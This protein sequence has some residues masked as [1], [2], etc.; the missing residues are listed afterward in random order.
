MPPDAPPRVPGVSA[1]PPDWRFEDR[2]AHGSDDCWACGGPA[3]YTDPDIQGLVLCTD[4]GIIYA[5]AWR[6]AQKAGYPSDDF[7]EYLTLW[8]RY[9]W[10]CRFHQQRGDNE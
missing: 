3:G 8:E 1:P 7:L 6:R 9:F 2:H 4:H 10:N 5:S